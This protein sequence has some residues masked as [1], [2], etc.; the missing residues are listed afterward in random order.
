[1]VTMHPV[2][3]STGL[4]LAVTCFLL[5]KASYG[6]RSPFTSAQGIHECILPQ[7]FMRQATEELGHSYDKVKVSGTSLV[8]VADKYVLATAEY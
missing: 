2:L 8:V 5:S 1:M 3:T 7:G 4:A 6:L